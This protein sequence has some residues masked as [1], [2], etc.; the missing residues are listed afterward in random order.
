MLRPLPALLP[1]L[2]RSRSGAR[3]GSM[4]RRPAF[5]VYTKLALE[6]SINPQDFYRHHQ[7]PVP[8]PRYTTSPGV[9]RNVVAPGFTPITLARWIQPTS[10][11][12]TLFN[13][14]SF[15]TSSPC[16]RDCRFMTDMILLTVKQACAHTPTSSATPADSSTST[17]SPTLRSSQLKSGSASPIQA[18]R[19]A[20]HQGL[21]YCPT[22]YLGSS[23]SSLSSNTTLSRWRTSW[24]ATV[25]Y[26][27]SSSARAKM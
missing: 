12:K 4:K 13:I 23:L 26:P 2:L 10:H 20:S 3:L 27:M 15:M 24:S 16:G 11:Q 9:P 1:A 5:S 25:S 22:D 18:T 21:T 19:P 6:L 17:G 8:N 14:Q 7:L